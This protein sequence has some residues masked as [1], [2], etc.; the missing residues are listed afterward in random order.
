M[1]SVGMDLREQLANRMSPDRTEKQL[2]AHSLL[3]PWRS[4]APRIVREP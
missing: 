3:K 2:D 4:S 1:M